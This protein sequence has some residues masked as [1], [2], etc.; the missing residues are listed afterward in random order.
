MMGGRILYHAVSPVHLVNLRLI[1]QQMPDWEFCM[2]YEPARWIEPQKIADLPYKAVPFKNQRVP[3]TIKA[4]SFDAVI[5]S[6]VQPRPEPLN[7]LLWALRNDI[8]TIALEESNQFALNNGLVNNY[9]APVDHLLVASNFERDHLVGVGIP[10]QRI[11]VTGWPFYTGRST[12]P[13]GERQAMKARLGLAVNRPVAALTL[14]AFGDAGE[15]A[16]V[17]IR[18]LRMA[19]EGLPEDFQLVIKPHPIEKMEILLGFVRE[20]ASRAVVIEGSVPVDDLLGGS[21]ILLN[22]GVSQVAIEALM[23]GVPVLVLAMGDKTP[24]HESA[25]CAIAETSEQVPQVLQRIQEAKHPLSLYKDFFARHIPYDPLEARQVTCAKIAELATE[26]INDDRVAQWLE[27]AL[28]YGWQIDRR[29]ACNI[30]ELNDCGVHGEALK[31]L[32]RLRADQQN[33]DTLLERWKGS[34]QEQ[35]LLCIWCAQLCKQNRLLTEREWAVMQ[36][37]FCATNLHLYCWSYECWGKFL[38]DHGYS[39]EYD[40]FIGK[41]NSFR[42]REST[43]KKVLDRLQLYRSGFWGRQLFL[44]STLPLHAKSFIKSVRRMKFDPLRQ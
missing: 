31:S 11:K 33:V 15:S 42:N 17:R 38:I 23:R 4:A 27:L 37:F 19:S 41:L 2:I 5:F 32:L 14:T 16:E 36:D 13:V 8:P 44:G 20:H 1:A 6:T 12:A 22:R 26:N 7:L 25:V 9:E 43:V 10:E 28:I 21:D 34:Y 3:G 40:Q 39:T 30:L 35:V 18:Q 24:F 29:I